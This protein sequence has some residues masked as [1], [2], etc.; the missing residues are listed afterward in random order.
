[1]GNLYWSSD[2][3][4]LTEACCFIFS[5]WYWPLEKM[6]GIYTTRFPLDCRYAT[7]KSDGLVSYRWATNFQHRFTRESIASHAWF[8]LWPN[9]TRSNC[10]TW[11]TLCLSRLVHRLDRV[12][13]WIDSTTLFP[14]LSTPNSVSVLFVYKTLRPHHA[15]TVCGLS[16][17]WSEGRAGRS[18]KEG[19]NEEK[20]EGE[21]RGS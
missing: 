5:Q 4:P 13:T 19:G 11:S 1:M 17:V 3:P 18:D 20:G 16:G 15:G 7:C 6:T 2:K 21:K 14:D 12:P 8:Q 9:V 10:V